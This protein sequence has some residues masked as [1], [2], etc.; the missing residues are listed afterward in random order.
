[1]HCAY[2]ETNMSIFLLHQSLF[3]IQT[4]RDWAVKRSPHVYRSVLASSS[5]TTDLSHCAVWAV[6][7]RAIRCTYTERKLRRKYNIEYEHVKADE[8]EIFLDVCHLFCDLFRFRSS[9]RSVRIVITV[10][11]EVGAKLYFHRRV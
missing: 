3:Q 10:R 9:Y 8:S 6:C 7:K 5:Q 11:N 1:M 4:G 2:R